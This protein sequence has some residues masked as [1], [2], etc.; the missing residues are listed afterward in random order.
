MKVHGFVQAGGGSTRFGTDKALVELGGRTL[1]ARTVE[2]VASVCEETRIVAGAGKYADV[3]VSIVA[4]KWP[5]Q[6]PLGGILTALDFSNE[7]FRG[8]G[9]ERACA[10]IVSCDMPF[11][12][13]EWLA[14]LCERAVKSTAQV[15]VPE[16]ENGLEPL[17]ACWR[18]EAAAA[19]QA[20]F[21][22]GV[23]K[24]TEAMKRLP[25]EVLDEGDWKRFDT[26]GRLFWNMN[27]AGDYEEARRVFAQRAIGG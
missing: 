23:R 15:V 4:D 11:L 14:Y 12:T 3:Q 16:S 9:G 8:A 5:G 2:L 18:T 13:G 1:L 24:V 26:D 19:V 10:L 25:M 6:G 7:K 22:G 17:C 20:A 21:D 27:T